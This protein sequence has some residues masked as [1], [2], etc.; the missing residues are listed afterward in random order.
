MNSFEFISKTNT[1]ALESAI[2]ALT[3]AFDLSTPTLLAL[4][5]SNKCSNCS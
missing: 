4:I 3:I 2:I 5:Y 1:Y